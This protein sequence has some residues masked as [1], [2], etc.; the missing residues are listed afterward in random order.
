[1]A[2]GSPDESKVVCKGCS[3][4]MTEPSPEKNEAD[5]VGVAV[6]WN[7]KTKDFVRNADGSIQGEHYDCAWNSVMGQIND[8]GTSMRGSI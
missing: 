2:K 7:P 1:L 8:L 4:A 5:K 6:K 3:K